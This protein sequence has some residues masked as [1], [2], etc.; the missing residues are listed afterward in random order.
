MLSRVEI[1]FD[2]SAFCALNGEAISAAGQVV[3]IGGEGT[4]QAAFSAY[5][6]RFYVGGQV[7]WGEE[8]VADGGDLDVDGEEGAEV[9]LLVVEESSALFGGD[10]EP[11]C[12]GID[13]VVSPALLIDPR[14]I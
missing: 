1:E 5:D 10:I 9:S 14:S 11:E 2:A 7:Y 12:G 8:G 6:A 13:V 3:H 4:D